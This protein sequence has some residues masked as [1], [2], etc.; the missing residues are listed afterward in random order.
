MHFARTT[1]AVALFTAL[2]AGCQPNPLGR[3]ALSGTV[4]FDS[5]PLAEGNISFQPTEGQATS[6]GAPIIN[7]QFAVPSEK[8]LA[9]GK[10]RV[11]IHAPVPGTGGKAEGGVLP[12]EA[13]TP[14]TE[15][16]PA[17]WNTASNQT[18]DVKKSGT[19]SFSFVIS[20]K[21]TD[22]KTN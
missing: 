2:L 19:N 21:P 15:R 12:G 13:P 18:I 6:G 5:Q 9:P 10:Y 17:E 4:Q 1:I 20:T 3:Q 14:P 7:G 16:I 11:I 22:S 8:G